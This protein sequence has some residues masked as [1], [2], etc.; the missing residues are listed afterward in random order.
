MFTNR[1]VLLGSFFLVTLCVLGYYTL[2]LTNFTLFRTEHL[3]T[4]RFAETN[5][6]REGDS[7]LV[8]GMRWG[9]VKQL[10]FDPDA[11]NDRRITVTARLNKPLVLRNNFKIQIEDATLLGGRNLSIDPGPAGEKPIAE[12]EELKGSVAPNTLDALGELVTQSQRGVTQIVQDLGDLTRG[13]REGKGTL[14]RI[15]TDETMAQNLADTLASASKSLANLDSITRDL[16]QGRGTAGQLLTNTEAYDEILAATRKLNQL[17]DQTTAI[18]G[19]V[20]GGKGVVSRLLTDEKLAAEFA[21]AVA[22]VRALV[23]K[24]KDGEGTLGQL[25]NDDTIASNVKAITTRLVNGEGTA[26]A[27]LTKTDVYDNLRETVENAAVFTAAIKNGQGSLGRLIMD[28]EVYDQVKAALR[29]VQRALEEYREA[30]PIT[31]FTAV[32]FGVF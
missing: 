27:L 1:S 6:L 22:D 10:D 17:L 26:G 9:Q 2:F 12:D 31:T 25:I 3:M 7:V 21:D 14:G 23:G 13:V 11:A 30:A 19:D 28:T 32:F 20:R 24:I 15:F 29:I 18:A 5:G 8:A 16:A 4:V